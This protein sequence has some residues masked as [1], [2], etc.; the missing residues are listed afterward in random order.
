MHQKYQPKRE[1]TRMGYKKTKVTMPVCIHKIQAD[2]YLS[3]IDGK[4][5]NGMSLREIGSILGVKYP[6]KV[7]HHL[8]QLRKLG[9]IDWRNGDYDFTN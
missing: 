1:T 9:T 8:E 6:Q 7:K 5:K 4:I 2:I 3:I